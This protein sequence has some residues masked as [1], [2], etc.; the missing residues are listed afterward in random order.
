MGR[1]TLGVI[2]GIVEAN[3]SE[4]VILLLANDLPDLGGRRAVIEELSPGIEFVQLPIISGGSEAVEK[5]N[6]KTVDTYV[7]ENGLSNSL[8]ILSSLFTFEYSPFCP[9][10]TL[11]A[12]IF[13]DMLPLTYWSILRG[14]FSEYEY[15]RRY[16]YIYKVDKI[17]SIS[18]HVKEEIVKYLGIESSVVVNISG[19]DV[20]LFNGESKAVQNT[21]S[22]KYILLPGGEAAHKN[23]YRAAYAFERFNELMGGMYRLV[24]T[25]F[26]S[27]EI[28]RDLQALSTGIEFSGQVSDEE[29]E[30]LYRGAEAVLFPSLDEG[31]GLPILEAVSYGKRVACSDIEVFKEF[32]ED[33]FFFFNPL[34][35]DD[36]ADALRRAVLDKTQDY[37]EIYKDI[38]TKFT[39]KATA[40]RLLAARIE[41]HLPPHHKRRYAIIVEQDGTY[42]LIKLIGRL[43]RDNIKINQI[44][45]YVDSLRGEAYGVP[46]V[47]DKFF[48]TSDL[49]D[50]LKFPKDQKRTVILTKKSK[51]SKALIRTGDEVVYSGTNKADVER[52]F[53]TMIEESR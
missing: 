2:K 32:S 17:F 28:K 35:P 15:F 21:L 22:Y 4:R 46:L 18:Q 20:S 3:S 53:N 5:A 38:R 16:I 9:T 37:K 42:D 31:L 48:T 34:N 45:L 44:E 8:F 36:I 13:Y 29:L 43:V 25:S 33:A 7:E 47:F 24:V 52:R 12:C 51:L 39:W 11:N 30:L 50:A 14:Y 10:K 26:Y 19:A 41:K 23:M 40:K 27:D 49:V 6:N 1:Y